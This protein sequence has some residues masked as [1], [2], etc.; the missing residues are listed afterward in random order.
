M[1]RLPVNRLVMLRTRGLSGPVFQ[2]IGGGRLI[3]TTGTA[4]RNWPK[5]K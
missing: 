2:N 4:Q 3:R 1:K 5:N